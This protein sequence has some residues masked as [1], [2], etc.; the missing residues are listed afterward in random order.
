MGSTEVEEM[1]FMLVL[2][3]QRLARNSRTKLDITAARTRQDKDPP[4]VEFLVWK[5]MPTQTSSC[6]TANEPVLEC[7]MS[8]LR[9]AQL[10]RII[11]RQAKCY[12]RTFTKF[13][14]KSRPYL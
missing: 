13:H 9:S 4:A 7:V 10:E 14:T 1:I 3:E 5:Y 8:T 6:A 2:C 11:L 12:L